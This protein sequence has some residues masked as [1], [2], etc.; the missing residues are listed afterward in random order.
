[1]TATVETL[2]TPPADPTPP[3]DTAAPRARSMVDRLYA[4]DVLRFLAAAFVVTYHFIPQYATA[5]GLDRDVAVGTF[6][7]HMSRYGYFG[8]DLFFIISGFVICMSSWGRSVSQFLTAR[9][10]RLAPA[11]ILSVVL[12]SAL[13]I[14]GRP[15]DPSIVDILTNFT[16][17]QGLVGVNDVSS[18][19]WTLLVELKFYLVFM[20]VVHFGV[21]Y[22][23]VVVFCGAWTITALVGGFT[24]NRVLETIAPPGYTHLF[25]GGIALYLMYRFGPNLL[26]WGM[27]IASWIFRLATMQQGGFPELVDPGAAYALITGFFLIM[28]AVA[29]RWMRWVRGRFLVTIGALTYPLYLIHGV[30]GQAVVST[31]HSRLEG[32]VLF[33]GGIAGLLIGSWLIHRLVEQPVSRRLRVALRRGFESIRQADAQ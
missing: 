9:I 24:Q 3:V 20:L 29:L 1:M 14:V 4:V 6:A 22:R 15:A 31:L 2:P 19:Y 23:R 11:Y 7:S 5:Y 25:V 33:A 10:T 27:V 30:V 16:M 28:L 18:V 12:L 26:L 17:V 21:T 13:L 8:V 32:P